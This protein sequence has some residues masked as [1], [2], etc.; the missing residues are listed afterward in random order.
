[1]FKILELQLEFNI[2]NELNSSRKL[3]LLKNSCGLSDVYFERKTMLVNRNITDNPNISLLR[4]C[5]E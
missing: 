4:V 2:F 1:M 5:Y 3:S